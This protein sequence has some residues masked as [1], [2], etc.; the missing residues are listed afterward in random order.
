[1]QG[2]AAGKEIDGETRLTFQ[3][4]GNHSLATTSLEHN[5]KNAANFV[6]SVAFYMFGLVSSGFLWGLASI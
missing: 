3:A 1:V 2:S 6:P 5:F 4:G